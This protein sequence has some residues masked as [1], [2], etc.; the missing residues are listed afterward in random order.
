MTASTAGWVSSSHAKEVERLTHLLWHYET[1]NQDQKE[2]L[3]LLQTSRDGLIDRIQSMETEK[4]RLMKKLRSSELSLKYE[5]SATEGLR[6]KTGLLDK[7]LLDVKEMLQKAQLHETDL[8][9]RKST[10]EEELHEE[11]AYRLQLVHEKEKLQG[12]IARLEAQ[13]ST[14]EKNNAEVNDRLLAAQQRL[15]T[16]EARN[17]RQEKLISMQSQEIL[18]LNTEILHTKEDNLRKTRH[19]LAEQANHSDYHLTID[20]MQEEISHLRKQLTLHAPSQ[21][22]KGVAAHQPSFTTISD[23]AEER[24]R[25]TDVVNFKTAQ[26]F[27]KSHF[28]P[29]ATFRTKNEHESNL[30]ASAAYVNLHPRDHIARSALQNMLEEKAVEGSELNGK[31]WI[32][33]QFPSE[34]QLPNVSQQQ[35]KRGVPSRGTGRSLSP[36]MLSPL[37]TR[38]RPR[39]A[40]DINSSSLHSNPLTNDDDNAA[41]DASHD[42]FDNPQR[43]ALLQW[44]RTASRQASRQRL[45]NSHTPS[46]TQ[47]QQQQHHQAHLQSLQDIYGTSSAYATTNNT[48]HN[49]PSQ[50]HSHAQSLGLH[51]APLRSSNNNHPLVSP[52][53]PPSSSHHQLPHTFSAPS[54]TLPG[55]HHSSSVSTAPPNL[56]HSNNPGNNLTS[57]SQLSLSRGSGHTIHE[58]GTNTI[59]H[60]STHAGKHPNSQQKSQHTSKKNK[61]PSSSS[62]QSSGGDRRSRF[63]GSGLGM[64]YDADDPLEAE[65]EALKH[66]GSTKQILQRIL[67]TS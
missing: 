28:V 52:F 16:L 12:D 7:E 3:D 20:A 8:G 40:L 60:N 15:E 19:V 11:R 27:K 54:M 34:I 24:K 29:N 9:G 39:N 18:A 58:Y 14:V 59:H 1:V 62:Q 53:S 38:D 31:S 63:V 57:L 41:F 46:E 25:I 45:S 56:M 66:Q 33:D 30:A 47:H 44:I 67:G 35:V 36:P 43:Q 37:A 10:L 61:K 22:A 48:S 26:R 65:L 64:R 5:K 51:S 6:K 17:T 21:S 49:S 13:L 50:T 2:Q 55:M 32:S 4:K 23:V 42:Y